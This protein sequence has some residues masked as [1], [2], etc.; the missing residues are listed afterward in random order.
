MK[1][2]RND[3]VLHVVDTPQLGPMILFALCL[4]MLLGDLVHAWLV[5]ESYGKA[6]WSAL[7]LGVPFFVC[8]SYVSPQDFEFDKA[9]RKLTWRHRWQW[10][11][12]GG[13][14]P[15]DDISDAA[16]E[17]ALSSSNGKCHPCALILRTKGKDIAITAALNTTPRGQCEEIAARIREV[18]RNPKA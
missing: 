8:F 10:W 11:A 14:L 12:Q 7:S 1:I 13:E 15:F 5:H 17:G 4:F 9:T 2:V 3:S 6:A 16:V 18:L